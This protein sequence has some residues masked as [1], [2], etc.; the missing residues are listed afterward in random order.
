MS[1]RGKEWKRGKKSSEGE[2]ARMDD[3]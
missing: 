3:M 1:G 2:T